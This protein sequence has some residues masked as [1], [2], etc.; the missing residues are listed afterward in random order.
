MESRCSS[1][2]VPVLVVALLAG[3]APAFA[4]D[5]PPPPSGADAVTEQLIT[6]DPV[7]SGA[8][9]GPIPPLGVTGFIPPASPYLTSPFFAH[10]GQFT[11]GPD[12]PVSPQNFFFTQ[13]EPL[14]K[15]LFDPNASLVLKHTAS[16]AFPGYMQG[17]VD[18]AHGHQNLDTGGLDSA[19]DVFKSFFEATDLPVD[20]Q[21]GATANSF[22]G[23]T[24]V[25][26]RWLRSQWLGSLFVPLPEKQFVYPDFFGFQDVR[27]RGARLYCAAR[28]AQVEQGSITPS[29]GKRAAYSFNLLGLKIDFLAL[30]STVVLNGPQRCTGGAADADTCPPAPGDGIAPNDGAQAFEIPLLLGNRL[31]PID[32]LLPGFAEVRVPLVLVSGD[33]EVQTAAVKRPVF[34]GYKSPCPSCLPKPVYETMHSKEYRTVTHTDAFLSAG[35]GYHVD[36]KFPFFILGP[37][38]VSFELSLDYGFGALTHPDDRVLEAQ[39]LFASWPKP[40]RKGWLFSNP[41][42][43]RLYNDGPWTL[44][45]VGLEPGS[46]LFF[47][48]RVLP[49][50]KTDPFWNQPVLPVLRPH[51][52]RTLTDDDHTASSLT[53]VALTGGIAGEL[54]ADIGP[55]DTSLK[56]TGSVSVKLDQEHVVRD[57]L[58]AQDSALAPP[59][60]AFGMRPITALT[61]R[62]RAQSSLTFNGLT[63]K[64]HFH[65]S[66]PFF[67]DINFDKKLFSVPGTTLTSKNTDDDLDPVNPNDDALA[68]RLGTG[69]RDGVPMTKPAVLS[70]LP[71][72]G[73]FETFDQDVAAC[74]ADPTPNLPTPPPCPASEGSGTPPQAHIC[75]YGPSKSPG[76]TLLLPPIPLNVCS[77]I[78]GYLNSLGFDA[79]RRSCVGRYLAFLCTPTSKT[80]PFPSPGGPNVVARVWDFDNGM[81]EDLKKVIDQCV[82]A[83]V[84][85]DTP[86][87]HAKAQDLV[88][89]GL[90]ATAACKEDGTLIGDDGIFSVLNPSSSPAAQ[91]APA[92]GP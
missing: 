42:T 74:L 23:Y 17:A 44:A 88:E 70:H 1:R 10:E 31:T 63:A 76:D 27:Q 68:F 13:S 25:R 57:A 84:P 35:K 79:P 78:P 46:P 49:Q 66:I 67:D 30:H 38:V 60:A 73:E 47:V 18:A 37:A 87:G 61:V 2:L 36:A 33:S 41:Q 65:L 12:I 9:D 81:A 28:R 15:P 3:A 56:V 86:D 45:S 29:L 89:G 80:Q 21:S 43:G 75:L 32:G 11:W 85:P 6:G 4:A 72:G 64:L 59:P 83:F 16:S 92:C 71:Q 48:W 40:T 51:D 62:T 5:D 19:F 22:L 39:G 53:S 52:L 8:V 82:I 14:W 26:A 54:S 24:P 20:I 55:F 91:P 90:I 50:G 58:R 77:N 69:S 7:S 34:L